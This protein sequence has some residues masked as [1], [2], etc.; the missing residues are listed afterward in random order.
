M[1]YNKQ[2]I[3]LKTRPNVL[4]DNIKSKYRVKPSNTIYYGKY[5]YKITF[6]N[7]VVDKNIDQNQNIRQFDYDLHSEFRDFAK[8]FNNSYK[9]NFNGARRIYVADFDDF[10]NTL[11]M[12]GDWVGE[13]QGPVSDNHLDLL[14]ST[15]LHLEVKSKLWHNK[16][17]YKLELWAS[18]YAIRNLWLNGTN[19]AQTQWK[20]QMKE[21][22]CNFLATI[23]AQEYNARIS[24]TRGNIYSSATL[25]FTEHDYKDILTFKT[26][27][28]PDYRTKLTKAITS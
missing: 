8:N 5:P 6:D 23:E 11:G 21:D 25:F 15:D 10:L 12:Y 27:M 28:I 19:K 7:V 14:Y 26:L 18:Y 2:S 24:D 20:T 22:L 1:I 17:D 13:V 16:Y 3:S 4:E 9:I